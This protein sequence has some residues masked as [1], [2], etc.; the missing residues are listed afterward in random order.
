MAASRFAHILGKNESSEKYASV[1]WHVKKG[2][3]KYLYNKE[4]G[5]FYKSVNLI[6][7]KYEI[8]DTVD[9]SSFYGIYYF[10]VLEA[11]NE[12]LN[13][14]F[15]M[16]K[17]RLSMQTPVGGVARYDNDN[18]HRVNHASPPNPWY[19]TTFWKAQY[20]IELAKTKEELSNIKEVI[21]WAINHAQASGLMAEQI[22]SDTG[23]QISACPLIWS[24]AELVSLVLSYIRK[25]KEL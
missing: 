10:K 22:K 8:Q 23:K 15:K 24:H 4:K 2:I 20:D 9:I 14:T 17:D 13:K 1:A 18:F 21:H 11:G 16:I 7:D 6:D 3:M 25:Y 19:I 5:Y 12:K